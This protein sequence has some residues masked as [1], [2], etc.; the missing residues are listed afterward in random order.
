MH[1][2]LPYYNSMECIPHCNRCVALV[3]P[4]LVPT[5]IS[6]ASSVCMDPIY[7]SLHLSL[8]CSM[9]LSPCIAR[10]SRFSRVNSPPTCR[11]TCKLSTPNANQ[12]IK[13]IRTW[14]QGHKAQ[15]R[16]L[17]LRALTFKLIHH[18]GVILATAP[19]SHAD[20]LYSEARDI[21]SLLSI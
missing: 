7:T 6:H 8:V 16:L 15:D 1:T 19:P 21:Y 18:L 12:S 4:R 3:I 17:Q 2:I 13:R 11:I 5:S 9:Q 10:V 20:I 14:Y